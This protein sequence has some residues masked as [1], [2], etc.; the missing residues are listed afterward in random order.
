M[1]A[2]WAR[3]D[4]DWLH[5][6]KLGTMTHFLADHASSQAPADVTI[7]DW[8]L[9]VDAVDVDLLAD[10]I[11]DA[12]SRYHIFT[13]GQNSG[14]YCSPNSTYDSIVGGPSR[15]SQRDLIGDLADALA[16]RGVRTIAYLPSHAPANYPQAVEALGF[17]PR[18]D[19]SQW[20]LSPG[21]Y[22]P[23]TGTDERL[24]RAQTNWEAV[25]REWSERWKTKISGWWFDGCYYADTMYR[26]PDA[27]NFRSFACAAKSG[28]PSSLVAFNPGVKMPVICLT[29]YE[30]YTAGELNDL[31]IGNKWHEPSRFVDG[32]Q[33]HVL[34]YLGVTWG[35]G[36]I[37][38]PDEL[39]A[40]YTRY[41]AERGGTV[42]WDIPATSEG[43]VP[44]PFLDQIRA[45]ADAL[46]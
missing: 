41:I 29:E 32:A 13:I 22:Q 26:H 19:P 3:A 20:S 37:R 10:Q 30:D 14:F 23:S 33:L 35:M 42:T 16:R 27:P 18:W 7:G 34:G 40:G 9:R 39:A 45:I 2:S 11:A 8:N 25:I 12:G 5:A 17:T 36:P 4:T 43:L 31:W 21:S 1:A 15:L 24:T 46:A 28:N 38:M 44:Q 6:A